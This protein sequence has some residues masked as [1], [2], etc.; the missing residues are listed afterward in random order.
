MILQGELH[1]GFNRLGTASYIDHVL[2]GATTELADNGGEFFQRICC[3]VVA[4]AVGDAV[5][6]GLD[7]VVHFRVGMADAVD[8]GATGT[9]NILL[10]VHIGQ[11]T[12]LGPHNFGKCCGGMNIGGQG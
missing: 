5:Q 12:P 11:I 6:L 9:I 3:E 7:G 4:V 10:A 1:A 2:E 8:G